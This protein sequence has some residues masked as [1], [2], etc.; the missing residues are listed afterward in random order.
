[1]HIRSY[2]SFLL[3]W[4]QDIHIPKRFKIRHIHES[5]DESI[6]LCIF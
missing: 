4:E 2:P 6:D 5:I 3:I 1:M